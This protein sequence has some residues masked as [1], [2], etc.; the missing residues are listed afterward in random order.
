MHERTALPIRP[1]RVAAIALNTSALDEPAAQRAIAD[2][3]AETGLVADDPVRFG[4]ARILDAVLAQLGSP[5]G[6]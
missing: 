2:S 3:E 5:E 1:C 4:A 6:R